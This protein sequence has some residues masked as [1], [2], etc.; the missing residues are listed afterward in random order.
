VCPPDL[1]SFIIVDQ[2]QLLFSI[3]KNNG[4]KGDMEKKGDKLAALW[5]NYE[6]FIKALG[7]LFT[8]LWSSEVRIEPLTQQ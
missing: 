1:P 6:A 7:T 2:E 3:K 5:T 4:R 8:E